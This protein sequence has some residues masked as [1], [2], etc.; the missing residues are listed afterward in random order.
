MSSGASKRSSLGDS[1]EPASP[2]YVPIGGQQCDYEGAG[3]QHNRQRVRETSGQASRV[4]G[5]P[6]VSICLTTYRRAHLLPRSLESLLSQTYQDFELIISD[7]CSPDHTEQ[8]GHAY[9][10]R[11]PRIR[12][13]RNPRNVG[14]I[15]NYNAAIS[16]AR[17]KFIA[18]THDGDIYRSDLIE[19]WV[20]A[21]ESYPSAAFAFNALE[22]IDQ[23]GQTLR[24]HLHPYPPLVEGT[25]L[26]DEMLTRWDSPVWGMVMLRRACLNAVG[27]F[28][29]RFTW[30]GD[31]DMWMRLLLRFDAAYVGEALI[32]V[33]RREAGHPLT[34]V[35]WQFFLDLE[36]IH[37]L[38]IGRRYAGEVGRMG[39]AIRRMERR[40]DWYWLRHLAWCV[41][42]RQARLFREGLSHFKA[43]GSPLLRIIGVSAWPLARLLPE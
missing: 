16:R 26:L 34:A 7:N 22:A 42:E 35:N 21:L 3:E 43:S 31:I 36:E 9:E 37:R 28:D 17:G 40:R 27:T 11:D 15:G 30:C 10:E 24:V 8:I 23:E 38:N 20:H 25:T 1:P 5:Q 12:Y 18:I 6:T 19:K 14:M 4:S 41:K 13:F 2:L 33:M 29:E 39:A 32:K